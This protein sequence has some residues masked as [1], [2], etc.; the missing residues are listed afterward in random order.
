M[1]DALIDNW[2]L[3]KKIIVGKE[4]LLEWRHLASKGQRIPVFGDGRYLPPSS[5]NFIGERMNVANFFFLCDC[6]FLAILTKGLNSSKE[7]QK[8][9]RNLH[10]LTHNHSWIYNSRTWRFT[11]FWKYEKVRIWNSL[12]FFLQTRTNISR[13]RSSLVLGSLMANRDSNGITLVRRRKRVRRWGN[14]ARQVLREVG[15]V[16]GLLDRVWSRDRLLLS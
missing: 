15:L 7:L 10:Y 2:A 11:F 5:I 6:I 1:F 8:K 12:P 9:E 3:T 16:R 4:D 13:T 14:H